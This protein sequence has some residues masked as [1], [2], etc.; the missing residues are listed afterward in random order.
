[1]NIAE[2]EK[3]FGNCKISG[4]KIIIESNVLKTLVFIKN[5]FGFNIL[6]EIIGI[7]KSLFFL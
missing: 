5:N 6:K 4:E 2:F 1:M 7:M 3:V